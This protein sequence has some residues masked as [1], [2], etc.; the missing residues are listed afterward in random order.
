[1]N[2]DAADGRGFLAPPEPVEQDQRKMTGP[3][4]LS[5]TSSQRPASVRFGVITL[6][7]LIAVQWAVYFDSFRI[8]PASDDFPIVNEIH[9]GNARGVSVFFTDSV[10]LIGYR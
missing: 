5:Q 2:N 1:M 8:L 10:I 4:D 6:L 7:C 3:K 9:R